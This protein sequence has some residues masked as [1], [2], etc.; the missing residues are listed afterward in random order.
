MILTKLAIIPAAIASLSICRIDAYAKLRA[1]GNADFGANKHLSKV[2]IG[3][4]NRRSLLSSKGNLYTSS[5]R[6]LLGNDT[7]LKS[8]L[9]CLSVCGASIN[10]YLICRK[11]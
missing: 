11:Q 3:V 4:R 1:L 8:G 7:R 10:Q 5:L 9:I 6:G 2:K